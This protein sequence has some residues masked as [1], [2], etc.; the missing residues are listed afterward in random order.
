MKNI[1]N[2]KVKKHNLTIVQTEFT[3]GALAFLLEK[4]DGS[5][6]C[7]VS[8]YP[9][10]CCLKEPLQKDEIVVCGWG[11]PA[12]AAQAMLDTGLFEDTGKRTLVTMGSGRCPEYPEGHIWKFKP[13]S[14]PG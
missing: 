14:E 7:Q 10:H 12:S 13:S 4:E 2:I 8:A 5:F 9:R 1:G 3:N 11:K 6:Y